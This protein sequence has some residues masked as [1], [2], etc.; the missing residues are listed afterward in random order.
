[1]NN[2][3]IERYNA[4]WAHEDTD[5]PI[6]NISVRDESVSWDGHAPISAQ[7][8]WENLE[9]RYAA[10]RLGMKSIKRFGDAIVHDWVNFGPGC[11]AAMMG[12][13]YVTKEDTVWF[14]VGEYFF[15]DYSNIDDLRLL[16]DTPMYKMVTDMTKM[17]TERND[18]SY[19]VGISD[20]GGNLDI[21]AS[22]RNTQDL[23]ADLYDEPDMVI[24]AVEIIDTA[25][26]EYYSMLRGII[27][28]SGQNGHTTWLGPWCETT[29]YP[30]QCD[31]A[32]MISPHDF[33]RFVMPSLK[34]I[35]EFLDHSIFHLDGPGQIVHLDHLLS[36][37]SL[38]GIQWVPGDGNPPVYDE[39]WFPM[40]EKIQAAGKC[41]VL[42]GIGSVDDALKICNNLSHKGLW[43]D[44]HLKSEAEAEKLLLTQSL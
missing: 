42:H 19:M 1:M 39:K 10:S 36:L 29:Y 41:L 25:W 11:L 9:A 8:K 7:E 21:L 18:G 2:D 31:F 33:E 4:F 14:G 34:R 32:Y 13:N 16:S 26:I 28:E 24:K 35:S 20:L 30:L 22:L 38:D 3:I 5:R 23:L 6:L 44:I 40:Y 17:L 37:P 15:K 12:S 27:K 43:L